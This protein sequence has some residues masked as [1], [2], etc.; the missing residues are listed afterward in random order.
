MAGAFE[1]NTNVTQGQI[2]GERQG[3]NGSYTEAEM[4][5]DFSSFSYTE[6]DWMHNSDTGNTAVSGRELNTVA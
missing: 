2:T 5:R 6:Y 3:G 4:E 1:M